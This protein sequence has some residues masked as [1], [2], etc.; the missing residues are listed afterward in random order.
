MKY[1]ILILLLLPALLT[2]SCAEKNNE[3]GDNKIENDPAKPYV[4]MLSMDGFRWNYTDRV[5]TPNFDK[6]AA[7]GVK[8]AVQPCFP[9]KTFPNHYSIATGLYP[10]HHGIV[11]NTFYDPK[12][13]S[14]YKISDRSK[15]EDG[16]YYGGEP[17]WNTAEKQ[18][19]RTASYFWVG[20]EADIQGMHPS[21]WKKYDHYFPWKQR[22]DSVIAWLQLPE[23]KRPHLILWYVPEPDGTGHHFGPQSAEIDKMVMKLD[24]LLG[25]FMDELEKIPVA[26]RVN[27]IVTSD[28]GMEEITHERM[29]SLKNILKND[30]YTGAY[31]G[32]PVYNIWAKDGFKDSIINALKQTGHIQAYDKN[33][34]PSRL[35]YMKNER[36]GD[37]VA[38]ADSAYGLVYGS[39]PGITTAGTHGYDNKNTNMNA[40]FYAYGPAFKK[41]YTAPV[42]QNIDIYNLIAEILGLKAAANDGDQDALQLLAE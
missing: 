23:S 22:A 5:P 41:G 12:R 31:G 11:N 35:H 16:Y 24:S 18:G 7:K 33:T 28:H 21:I 39:I 9:T 13:K 20:S 26:S 27:V 19:M 15:V 3:N 40:M 32:N 14:V 10:D 34:I 42:F 30:W 37:V 1:K 29:L 8:S 17:I 25:Y 6:I 4:V 2:F 36:C 38:V